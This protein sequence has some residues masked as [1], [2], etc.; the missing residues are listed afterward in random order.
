MLIV[1]HLP[2]NHIQHR[3]VGICRF[4]HNSL[5]ELLEVVGISSTPII[6]GPILIKKQWLYIE[7][8][9]LLIYCFLSLW[10]Q[11]SWDWFPWVLAANAVV[12]SSVAVVRDRSSAAGTARKVWIYIEPPL[13][14]IFIKDSIHKIIFGHPPS[15]KWN[16]I[17]LLT[18][19]LTSIHRSSNAF[20]RNI[21]RS[22]L[23]AAGMRDRSLIESAF[24]HVIANGHLLD[25]L[26]PIHWVSTLPFFTVYWTWWSSWLL[27]KGL[28]FAAES[29]S[30]QSASSGFF[31]FL[32]TGNV[33]E[34]FF[35]ARAV[36]AA[37]IEIVAASLF[38]RCLGI[39]LGRCVPGSMVVSR[40]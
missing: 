15:L 38:W 10:F 32:T 18:Q 9:L 23:A 14:F 24:S 22:T 40:H 12:G 28:L 35:R 17:Q 1:D 7:L 29:E 6:A 26:W 34:F 3:S 21:S 16:A 39:L 27:R 37:L 30:S 8:V 13:P 31:G 19:W 11:E 36:F 5:L 4:F 25:P 33:S 2:V 20:P